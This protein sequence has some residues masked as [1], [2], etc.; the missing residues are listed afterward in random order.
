L[1][2]AK[3]LDLTF[4]RYTPLSSNSEMARRTLTPLTARRIEQMKARGNALREQPIDLAKEK[5]SLYLP[6]GPQPPAGYGLIVFIPPW[7]EPTRPL[8]WRPALDRRGF[9]VVSAE[10]SGNEAKI[11]DR[12]LPLALLGYENVRARY[13][14]DPDRVYV[15]GFSGGS[16]AAEI[17]ALAYPDVFRGVLLNAGSDPIGGEQGIYL[18]P[19]D[20][21]RRFQRSRLVF[22][23][24]ERDDLNLRDDE[25]S[26]ASLRD[27]CVFEIEVVVARRLGHEALD[28]PSLE[29][30]LVALDQRPQ[31][32]AARLDTCN[33]ALQAALAAK[34]SEAE[35]AMARGD[36]DGARSLLKVMDAR[37]AGLAA[38]ALRDLED[39]LAAPR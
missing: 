21:F 18:P 2:P 37:Y 25:R 10:N 13:P 20:L 31:V 1:P 5:F 9:I 7:A 35:A 6:A 34:L 32:D 38:P 28:R 33:S 27:H 17:A 8:V 14:I 23:T 24:G 39:R 12:R 4:D 15:G 11:L 26:R 3:Q 29:R 30:S 19:A 16:R 22:V 36:R